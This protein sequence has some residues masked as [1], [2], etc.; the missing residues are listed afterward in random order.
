MWRVLVAHWP[1]PRAFRLEMHS[2]RRSLPSDTPLC[3]GPELFALSYPVGGNDGHQRSVLW[4]ITDTID[5]VMESQPGS[6]DLYNYKAACC[7]L[8]RTPFQDEVT[9]VLASFLSG[10]HRRTCRAVDLGANA[11]LVTSTMLWLGATVV[12]V[13]PQQDLA[14]AINATAQLN[15]WSHRS[16]VLNAKACE[17][18]PTYHLGAACMKPRKASAGW[19]YAGGVP[20]AIQARMALRPVGGLPLDAVF[21]AGLDRASTSLPLHVDLIKAD[22]DRPEA[23]WLSSIERM[24]THGLLSVG[25]IV[26][27]GNNLPAA[28]LVKLQRRHRLEAF[29]LDAGPGV[30]W[31]DSRRWLSPNTGWDRYSPPGTIARLERVRGRLDR[32]LLEEE[33]FSLR[34]MRHVFRI[35]P[36]LTIAQWQTVNAKLLNFDRLPGASKAN[37]LTRNDLLFVN[38]SHF[39]LF[40]KPE[41][42]PVTASSVEALAAGLRG[43]LGVDD[44]P[45]ALIKTGRAYSQSHNG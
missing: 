25:A 44:K 42:L 29:R 27:E 6:C 4:P 13:E 40:H 36:N 17:W 5:V 39:P 28:T 45:D 18:P 35:K 33:I 21:F 12:S 41:P 11:G 24:L 31:G 22:G 14:K 32:D 30:P 10:C 1:V 7:E 38:T 8:T 16:I 3:G 23:M 20:K 15:C 37:R 19:R 26:I 2:C 43:G 34:A 9:A